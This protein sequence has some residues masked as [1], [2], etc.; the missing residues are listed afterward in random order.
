MSEGTDELHAS[1][2]TVIAEEEALL[3]RV[4][5]TLK[6]AHEKASRKLEEGD[7]RSADALRALREEAAV[8]SADDLPGVLHEMSVRQR[9]LERPSEA[10]LPDLRSPYLAHLV[11]QE[12]T[13][14][15]H[16]LLG[17]TTF[18]DPASNV[19]IV[20]WRVAPIAKI[21]Y[22]YREG[23]E[24]EESF[25]GREAEGEV[26]VRRIVVI[27]DGVLTQILGDGI[28][29]TRLP[30]GRWTSPERAALALRAGGG[31]SANVTAL[32]DPEQ[33]AAV[34]SPPD[35]PLLVLGSAGSGKTT[36]ALHRL[37]HLTALRPKELPIARTRVI[38]PEEGLAR[39]SRR[40]L[41]P[42]GAGAAQ[43]KT[44]DAWSIELARKVF[45]TPIRKICVDPPGVV[46]SLKRH[47]ALFE[48]LSARFAKVKPEATTFRRLRRRLATL[49]TDRSFLSEVVLASAG[50][51]SKAAVED[52]VRHTM[53]QLA[54]PVETMLASITVPEMKQAVDGRA[55]ADGT[56]DELA[57]T[58]DLEDLPILLFLRAYRAG[59]D[60]AGFV[61]VVLDEAEDFSLFELF[62]IGKLLGET[63][64]VTL[65][66]DEAQQ[67]ASS[68][69]GWETAAR[70]LGFDAEEGRDKAPLRTCRL[71]VSY[72]CPRPVIEL[73]RALL[74]S[75]APEA[76]VR[77]AREGAPVGSFH[78][79]DEGQAQLFLA[80]A[81]RDLLDRE[82]RASV[83]VIARD[84]E[85]ARRVHAVLTTVPDVRLV[86]E[87]EFTFEPGAD[88][89]DVDNAKGLEFD[90]VIVP[91]ASADAYPMTDEARRRL[92]VAVTRTSHQL[93][94]LSSGERS[95][96]L[97]T[98]PQS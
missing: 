57:G 10:P 65:A 82:P 30:D 24:Y 26:K 50:D 60:A 62:V 92:H 64:S 87:G 1:A 90:Y 66:G 56:P 7:L 80:G 70:T 12:G 14:T 37:A 32:L 94:L 78:F 68:F 69:A 58:V 52:T 48:A 61:H 59:L 19:R 74:G 34:T 25:P 96:L 18:L 40:L 31:G 36:V 15:K 98:I 89:T 13:G 11:V 20:D 43:V 63:R 95:P 8:T 54:E 77:V 75:F 3:A 88:V 47:P 84:A 9:L 28:A 45:D 2:R 5:D 41:E 55:I 79:P 6:K 72:R 81:I 16:Y 27:A 73:A 44:L 93:W 38:V 71:A 53:L 67:T 46:S 17:N 22:A 85:T 51:L 4:L 21:F 29:L 49:F 76:P 86:L 97:P 35:Q 42:L 39:L 83:G 33:Y 91:D 23:D